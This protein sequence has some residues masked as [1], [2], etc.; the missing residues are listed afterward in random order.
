M[1]K[2]WQRVQQ[3]IDDVQL[4]PNPQLAHQLLGPTAVAGVNR[5]HVDRLST[6]LEQHKLEI[7]MGVTPTDTGERAILSSRTKLIL[8]LL[9]NNSGSCLDKVQ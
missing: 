8:M 1:I 3:V 5:I 7:W 2:G 9:I 6:D 4:T